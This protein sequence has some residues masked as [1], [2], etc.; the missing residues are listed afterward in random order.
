MSTFDKILNGI[1]QTIKMQGHIQ[2]LSEK[3][4]AVINHV[5]ENE[6]E[7]R[8]IDKRLIRIETFAEMADR[9]KK[10]Q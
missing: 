1:T 6:K 9:L 8:D 2:S 10:L 3:I 5:K 4:D 7:M